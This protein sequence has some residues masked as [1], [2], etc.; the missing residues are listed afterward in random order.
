[1]FTEIRTPA[2]E[3]AGTMMRAAAITN[4][5]IE[6]KDRIYLTSEIALRHLC[7]RLESLE[8][9]Q[10]GHV[11]NLPLL[12]HTVCRKVPHSRENFVDYN[13][14]G[15]SPISSRQLIRNIFLVPCKFFASPYKF[16][17][18]PGFFIDCTN[19]CQSFSVWFA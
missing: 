2:K 4:L 18:A 6:L 8:P 14:R 13:E 12:E 10:T 1:M 9:S 3:A 19:S 7:R 15:M 16:F 17:F 5:R 11:S